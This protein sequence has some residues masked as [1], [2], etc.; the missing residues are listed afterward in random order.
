MRMET[1]NVSKKQHPD[2]RAE[3]FPRPLSI[4][5]VSEASRLFN[6]IIIVFSTEAYFFLNFFLHLYIEIRLFGVNTNDKT[7][8]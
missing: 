4:L 3:H 2:K 7:I 6:M 5:V 1:V 8:I